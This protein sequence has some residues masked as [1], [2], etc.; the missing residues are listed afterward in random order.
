MSGQFDKGLFATH[1]LL[2]LSRPLLGLLI[3]S[4]LL[5]S[6]SSALVLPAVI[7]ACLSDYYDGK[8]ARRA[9]CADLR[10][11]VIDNVC[12]A[13]FLA[14]AMA[15]FAVVAV[16][17]DLDSGSASS[18]WHYANWIP[19]IALSGSFGL[20]LLRLAY[21]AQGG[22]MPPR[23]PRG[24]SAGVANYVLVITGAVAVWP[25]FSMTPLIT[26]PLSIT[27][28]L[29]NASAAGENLEL[30]FRQVGQRG[31]R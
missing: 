22:E 15:G 21:T 1:H 26:E 24:H 7:A 9:G 6:D 17:S 19:L 20:Y 12:D 31:N 18:Y 30:L 13:L 8:L 3:L 11:L 29:L 28:A 16:W 25:G 27:V 2:S 23:S 4:E 10:G 14:A 5:H